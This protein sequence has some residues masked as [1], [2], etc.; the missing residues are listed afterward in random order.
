[1]CDN[2]DD[3]RQ[4]VSTARTSGSVGRDSFQPDSVVAGASVGRRR[5]DRG[6]RDR[7]T[8][9]PVPDVDARRPREAADD[10]LHGQQPH[11]ANRLPVPRL[12]R[13]RRGSRT[14]TDARRS[15]QSS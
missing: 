14:A 8:R 5:G 2:C 11:R 4:T 6:V 12:R 10:R 13:E 7:A 15:S 9:A 3:V 1:V